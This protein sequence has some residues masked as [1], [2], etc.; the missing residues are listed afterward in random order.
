[1]R[2]QSILILLPLALA[3]CRETVG[4]IP[5]PALT[6]T[7]GAQVWRERE[8]PEFSGDTVELNNSPDDQSGLAGVEIA[9][10]GVDEAGVMVPGT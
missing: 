2:A 10:T 9:F 8:W 7:I 6:V 1:M 3:A 5:A 4:P